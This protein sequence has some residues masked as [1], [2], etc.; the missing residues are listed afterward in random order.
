MKLENLHEVKLLQAQMPPNFH[1]Q[2]ED[3]DV[4]WEY[5]GDSVGFDRETMT[6][7][8]EFFQNHPIGMAIAQA[9]AE[10]PWH[11]WLELVPS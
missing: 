9:F 6:D 2:M 4:Y 3:A 11:W 7:Y 8:P 10:H 1:E 5:N